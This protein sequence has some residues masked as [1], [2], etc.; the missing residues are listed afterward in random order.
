LHFEFSLDEISK[1]AYVIS[2]IYHG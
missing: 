1:E 2:F